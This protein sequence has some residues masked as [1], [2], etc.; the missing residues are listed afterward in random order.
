MERRN[1]S[2][3]LVL[4]KND[5][6]YLQYQPVWREGTMFLFG[7]RTLLYKQSKVSC[8]SISSFYL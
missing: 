6:W 1:R 4:V 3:M 5:L 8:T 2:Y 7:F